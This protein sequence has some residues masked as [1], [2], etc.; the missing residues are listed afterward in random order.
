MTEMHPV[1]AEIFLAFEQRGHDQYGSE[2]V[3]QLQHGLQCGSLARQAGAP[4]RLVVAALLHDIGHILPLDAASGP[5]NGLDD[6]H[7]SRGFH[8]LNEN[9]PPE[10]SEPV[11]LHVAAKRYL[12]TVEPDYAKRLSPTSHQSFLD[13]GGPM[14]AEEVEMFESESYYQSAVAL[15][16]WDDTGKDPEMITLPLEAFLDDLRQSLRSSP[17]D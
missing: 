4:A 13:Q 7:E 11:R 16:R 10:V 5:K 1:V 2:K 8:W 12:C 14:S 9:F 15:R 17:V 6:K 3:T